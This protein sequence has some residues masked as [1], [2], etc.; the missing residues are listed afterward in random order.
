MNPLVPGRT[1]DPTAAHLN[2]GEVWDEAFLLC[3]LNQRRVFA[4]FA[5]V[6][7]LRVGLIWDCKF[8]ELDV[9]IRA[10]DYN[11]RAPRRIAMERQLVGLSRQVD[12]DAAV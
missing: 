11:I 5:C 9:V 4:V 6:R 1:W 2:A 7:C 3:K 8:H 10:E 12:L